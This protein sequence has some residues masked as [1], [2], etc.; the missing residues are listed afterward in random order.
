MWYRAKRSDPMQNVF[1]CIL[2]SFSV[3]YIDV[4]LP[5]QPLKKC[6]FKGKWPEGILVRQKTPSDALFG[7]KC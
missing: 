6:V 1:D 7:E 4:G 5:Q 3:R 2:L